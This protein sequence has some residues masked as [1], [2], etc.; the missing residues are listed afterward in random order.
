[1]SPNPLDTVQRFP[2]GP[3]LDHGRWCNYRQLMALIR[4]AKALDLNRQ[5]PAHIVRRLD[6]QGTNT[7]SSPV[8]VQ[9]HTG[10][11]GLIHDLA[12]GKPA[13]PHVRT[14]AFIKLRG[15]S[16]AYEQYLDVPYPI[17][18]H[19]HLGRRDG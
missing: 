9:D 2:E 13:P 15:Q 11:L 14:H 19:W 16:Q 10:E 1:M 18:Q 5:L 17:W 12:Q 7:F 4:H 3:P 8:T 6:P